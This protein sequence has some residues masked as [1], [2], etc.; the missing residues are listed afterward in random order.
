MLNNNNQVQAAL[1]VF[2]D[3]MDQAIKGGLYNSA[4]EVLVSINAYNIL[5]AAFIQQA[6]SGG[7]AAIPGHVPQNGAGFQTAS[8]RKI[9]GQP[10]LVEKQHADGSAG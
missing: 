9:Q 10:A 4:Q 5:S 8:E 6:G 1:G 3:M 2:K 7:Q